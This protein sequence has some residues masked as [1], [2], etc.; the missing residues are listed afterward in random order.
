MVYLGYYID[1]EKMDADLEKDWQQLLD[2][3]VTVSRKQI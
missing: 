3:G 2:N 1:L